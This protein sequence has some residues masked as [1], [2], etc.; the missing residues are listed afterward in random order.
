MTR[1]D[2]PRSLRSRSFQK[3]D[4]S[5]FIPIPSP[6]ARERE[7]ESIRLGSNAPLGASP[8]EEVQTVQG[9]D[10]E[11][12]RVRVGGVD[13]AARGSR[14]ASPRTRTRFSQRPLQKCC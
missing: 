12:R 11:H 2:P 13:A 4:L 10:N 6:E 7:R 1:S 14:A 8:T 3:E 5:F 9:T